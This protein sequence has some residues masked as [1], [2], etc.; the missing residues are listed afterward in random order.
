MFKMGD[1]FFNERDGRYLEVDGVGVDP[2]VYSCIEQEVVDDDLVTVG[3]VLLKEGEL[4]KM[5]K[6]EPIW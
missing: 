5:Q 1:G 3:R 6:Q 4:E 2:T